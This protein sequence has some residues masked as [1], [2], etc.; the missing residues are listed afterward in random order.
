MLPHITNR[1]AE[2]N[3]HIPEDLIEDLAEQYDKDTAIVILNMGF[4][5]NNS[6]RDFYERK[7]SNGELVILVVRHH[8]A[9]TVFFRRKDQPLDAQSLKVNKVVDLSKYFEKIIK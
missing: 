3:L 6:S 7:E 1:L 8:E 4:C 5:V 2:R 9:I